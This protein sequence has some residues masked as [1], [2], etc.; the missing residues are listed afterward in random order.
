LGFYRN[1]ERLLAIVPAEAELVALS[2]HDDRWHPDKLAA[3][4]ASLGDAE[5]AYSDLRLVDASGTVRAETFWEGRRNNYENL[6]SLIVSNTVAGAACLIRRRVAERALP[7]PAGPGWDFH[8]H[9]LA[10]VALSMGRIAYVDRPLYDYVQHPGAVLGHVVSEAGEAPTPRAGLRD[11]LAAS[12]GFLERWR[13]SYFTA[14]LQRKLQADVLDARCADELTARKR[15][16]LRLMS[17]ADRSPVAFG[18]L[19]SRPLRAAA[20]RNETLG[21]ERLLA[22]GII[23]RH[24]M[25]ARKIWKRPGGPLGDASLPSY[26]SKSLGGS[27]RRWLAR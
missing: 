9:W 22:R 1:F 10:L 15:R 18:W 21:V 8:D 26:D 7:F 14:Y 24:L 25:S 5:L 19:V 6:A 11:R 17:R 13:R 27:R 16:A 3:L 2:D 20:G 12:R 23:W 4:R